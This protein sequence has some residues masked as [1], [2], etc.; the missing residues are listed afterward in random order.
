MKN[1]IAVFALMTLVF[2]A[3]ENAKPDQ[4]QTTKTETP[5]GWDDF[6]AAFVNTIS[7]NDM[8]GL[9]EIAALPLKGNFFS[10]ENGTLSKAGLIKNYAKVF[11][12]DVRLRIIKAQPEEWG[13]ATI[14][15]AAEAERIG[16]PKGAKVKTLQLNYVFNEGKD[17]QTESTQI[18]YFAKL[19][20]KYKWCSMFIAG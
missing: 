6:K 16:V 11:G 10:S 19:D 17:N 2:L 15:N 14:T 13:E 18:F 8:G 7:K 9:V 20:G 1:L 3:C 4:E 5:K 12:G